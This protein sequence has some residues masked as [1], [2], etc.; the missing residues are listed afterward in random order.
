M[1]REHDRMRREERDPAPGDRLG[2]RLRV[3][4]E[5]VCRERVRAWVGVRVRV[6]G[7][8]DVEC[9]R[10]GRGNGRGRAR[11][12]GHHAGAAAREH[13]HRRTRETTHRGPICSS[14]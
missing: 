11:E 8:V 13:V 7:N 5:E 9:V 2:G 10:E 14:A 6:R 4:G 1:R 3:H 12:G